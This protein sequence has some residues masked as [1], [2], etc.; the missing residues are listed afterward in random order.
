[1]ALHRR[2]ATTATALMQRVKRR[3]F[4]HNIPTR[5]EWFAATNRA[6]NVH[7]NGLAPM[8]A[9]LCKGKNKHAT[10]RKELAKVKRLMQRA[11]LSPELD[12]FDTVDAKAS[13]A[14]RLILEDKGQRLIKAYEKL[15]P[16]ATTAVHLAA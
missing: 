7:F 11:R 6:L 13:F 9:T 1:M 3:W 12:R 4:R 10:F 5:L 2:L 16:T 8:M 15:N 14:L